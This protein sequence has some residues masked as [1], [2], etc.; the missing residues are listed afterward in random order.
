MNP[1]AID[2]RVANPPVRPAP[3]AA[4]VSAADAV[5]AVEAS[6]QPDSSFRSVCRL[7]ALE[8]RLLI[9]QPGVSVGLIAFP[10]VTMLVLAG[11]FGQSPDPEFGGARPDAYY[12]VGYIG[13]VL[14]GLGLTTMPVHLATHRE[15]GVLRRYRAAGLSSPVIVGGQGLLGAVIGIIAAATVGV[16]G[17]AVYGL[18]APDEPVAVLAWFLVALAM[19]I[20]IGAAL[21]FSMPSGR[22]ASSIGN[23]IFIPAFLL[24]GGGPPRAVMTGPMQQIHDVLPLSHITGGMRQ[25]WLGTTGEPHQMWWPLLVTAICTAIAARRIRRT[26]TPA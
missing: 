9:R 3:D 4:T 7:A 6:H 2:Q 5:G 1:Y 19:F 15:L 8:I 10:L 21:G 13:V 17:A 12:V 26:E 11:V 23:L 25:A 16:A 18:T 20:A 24:G 22:A 14:A